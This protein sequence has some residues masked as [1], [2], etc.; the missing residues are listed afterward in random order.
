MTPG[1]LAQNVDG[2]GGPVGR[3]GSR[4]N[5]RVQSLLPVLCGIF[6]K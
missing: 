1:G 4:L 6:L 2:A 3:Q 5:S